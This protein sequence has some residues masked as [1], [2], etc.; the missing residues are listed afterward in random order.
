MTIFYTYS[1][2][3]LLTFICLWFYRKRMDQAIKITQHV[4]ERHELKNDQMKMSA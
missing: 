3:S 1:I 2:I 4:G